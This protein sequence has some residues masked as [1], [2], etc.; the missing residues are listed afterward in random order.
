MPFSIASFSESVAK[1]GLTATA[2]TA[3]ATWI[4]TI[5]GDNITLSKDGSIFAVYLQSAAVA[6]LD[7]GRLRKTNS[8]D[9]IHV[10]SGADQ[11]TIPK[12]LLNCNYGCRKNDVLNCEID[13]GNNAQLDGMLFWYGNPQAISQVPPA[14]PPAS[15]FWVSGAGGTAAV[16]NTWTGSVVTW[17]H[18]FQ[19]AKTYRV[20]GMVGWSATGYGM[21]IDYRGS[22]NSEWEQ[23]V[24]G[25]VCG[26]TVNCSNPY[27]GNFGDFQGSN[28]P[29]LYILASGTDA[30]Q[31]ISLLVV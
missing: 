15:A 13:N 18:N 11:T 16:A 26:D 25:I 21:G 6:N 28:P 29:N 2:A 27:Y 17:T 22:S 1:D 23:F 20:L 12:P 3:G 10:R 7:E 31:Y 9:W 14:V 30:A 8:Q 5:V 19:P 24:P 4:G